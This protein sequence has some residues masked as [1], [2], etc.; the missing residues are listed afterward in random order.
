ME[1]I[2]LNSKE[3]IVKELDRHFDTIKQGFSFFGINVKRVSDDELAFYDVDNNLLETH[4]YEPESDMPITDDNYYKAETRFYDSLGRRY[5]YNKDYL[6]HRGEIKH[7]FV[8]HPDAEEQY[9][10]NILE[11]FIGKDDN[12]IKGIDIYSHNEKEEYEFKEFKISENDLQLSLENDR[13]DSETISLLKTERSFW[14]AT[15]DYGL[16]PLFYMN[17]CYE[18]GPLDPYGKNNRCIGFSGYEFTCNGK[19]VRVTRG[20]TEEKYHN[21]AFALVTHPRNQELISYTIN[22]FRS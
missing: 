13:F 18:A 6:D 14:Y 19:E 2:I 1:K 21:L 20:Y 15:T 11:I 9:T 10:R 8:I 5:D 4:H 22:E 17:E 16:W 3:T 7:T 12:K